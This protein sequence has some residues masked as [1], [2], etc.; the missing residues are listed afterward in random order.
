MEGAGKG[1][2]PRPVNFK[3]LD[4]C[5]LWSKRRSEKLKPG[6]RFKKTYK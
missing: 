5:P 4:M 1:P 2:R 3:K 6:Q